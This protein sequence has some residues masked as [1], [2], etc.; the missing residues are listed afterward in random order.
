MVLRVVIR[1]DDICDRYDFLE[2]KGWFISH[3]P[4]IPISFYI[5]Y[6]HENYR[7]RGE[8]WKIIKET[9]IDYK[10]EIGGHSRN[11]LYL[12]NLS[13]T[14]LKKEIVNNIQD[15]EQNLKL[16]GLDYKVTSFAYPYGGFDKR[17]KK[18]LKENGIIHGLTYSSNNNYKSQIIFTIN[19]LYEIGISCNALN[20]VNDWNSR[21][22]NAYENGDSYILCLHTSHWRRE[23]NRENLKRIFKSHSIKELIASIKLFI[24]YLFKKNSLEKWNDLQKHIDYILK[25]SNVNFVT[26]K[27]LIK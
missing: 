6:T 11:H 1:I 18:I 19:N 10:W 23:L 13:I 20:S 8:I 14:R 5:C 2:L 27:D 22:D 7:W 16:V 3:Y 12:P 24:G 9:I 4:Q 25:F 15:I 21:F 26:F 17:V